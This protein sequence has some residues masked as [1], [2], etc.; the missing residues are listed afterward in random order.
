MKQPQNND[1]LDEAIRLIYLESLQKI[2]SSINEGELRSVMESQ[3]S[4]TINP[5]IKSEMINRLF[6]EVVVLSFGELLDLFLAKNKLTVDQLAED[7]RVSSSV[8][9]NLKRDFTLIHYVPTKYIGS[10][11]KKMSVSY[12]TAEQSILKTVNLIKSQFN[13]GQI[14]FQTLSVSNGYRNIAL[15]Q[16]GS[17]EDNARNVNELL[18]IDSKTEKYLNALEEL[19]NKQ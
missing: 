7:I 16:G 6:N 14:S 13:L 11:L 4:K 2:D 5:D 1:L 15:K 8:I 19:M 17:K 3:F 9:E 12:Q 18:E 10:L